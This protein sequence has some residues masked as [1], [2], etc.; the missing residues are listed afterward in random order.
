MKTKRGNMSDVLAS[1]AV[2]LEKEM[3]AD[4]ISASLQKRTS[5]L[6]IQ[7]PPMKK[8]TSLSNVLAANAKELEKQ[9]LVDNV[10]A[11]LSRRSSQQDLL[12]RGVLKR[13]P[14]ESNILAASAVALE[15]AFTSDRISGKIATTIQAYLG[16]SN[17]DQQGGESS[18][19]LSLKERTDAYMKAI[20]D[21]NA[22]PNLAPGIRQRM[23]AYEDAAKMSPVIKASPTTFMESESLESKMMDS[24]QSSLKDRLFAYQD[25]TAGKIS[26]SS[27]VIA[28]PSLKERLALYQES[29][30]NMNIAKKQVEIDVV[31][32]VHDKISNYMDTA[33]SPL[34]MDTEND[35]L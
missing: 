25:S 33:T 6:G 31:G 27:P 35:K 15:K 13:P 30:N 17:A 20:R 9:M 22:A 26:P 21:A 29:A 16:I 23:R 5:E 8:R 32:T 2:Q 1:T 14:S 11:G 34:E 18:G 19:G 24:P 7:Q 4:V 3:K 28:G 12:D 10:S